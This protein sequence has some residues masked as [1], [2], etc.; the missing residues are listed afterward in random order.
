MEE[1]G[2]YYY[3]DHSNGMDNLVLSNKNEAPNCPGKSEI[4][5]INEQNSDKTKWVSA[6][7]DW[8]YDYNLQT[9]KVTLWDHHFQIPTQKH[10]HVE[11]SIFDAGGNQNMEVYDFP[12]GYT[13][14]YDEV[15]KSGNNTQDLQNIP[16]D[17]QRTVK[18]LVQALD[19]EFSPSF[20]ISDCCTVTPGHKF[21]LIQH[22]VADLNR[23]YLIISVEQELVQ[24]PGYPAMVDEHKQVSNSFRCIPF[25][26]KAPIYKPKRKTASPI[27]QG[28]QTA[29]VVGPKNQEIHTDKY[30]RVKIKFHWD[31]KDD[32]QDNTAWVRVG[33]DIA[34]NKW[35]TMYIPRVGQ[36]VIV[37]FLYGNPDEPIIV[38]SVYNHD[39]MPHYELPK[40]KTLT[41]IKTRTSPDDGKGYN[42]LRFEDKANKEQ[43]FIRSQ[44]R[45]DLRVRGSM[46]ETCGGNRQEVIGFKQENQPGG[47]LAV[48]V[49]GNYDLHVKTDQYITI[50][51][52]LNE[53]VKGD[54][55]EGYDSSQSTV[56]KSKVEINAQTIT[57]E[58]SQAVNLRV[59]SSCIIVDMMGITIQGPM[60]KINSGGSA[61]PTSPVNISDALDAETSDTGEPGYLDKPRTGGGGGRKTRTLNGQHAPSVTKNADGTYS[62]GGDKLRVKGDDKYVSSVMSDLSKMYNTPSGKKGIDDLNAGTGTTTIHAYTPK[63]GAAKNAFAG[64]GAGPS[65]VAD[66][67]NATPAGQP[68]FFGNGAP[69]KDAAGN[70]LMG[71]G[72]GGD[73]NI[74]YNPTDWPDPTTKSKAPGD[75]ILFHEMQHSKNQTTGN[76]DGTPRTD[77]F[78]TNEEFNAIGPENKY[79]DERGV[80]R[81]KNHGD[82]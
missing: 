55:V 25:G 16:A 31:Q 79:R 74:S 26:E 4:P 47:N 39:T 19:A 75:V 56:V 63:P 9:G 59:G 51:G 15:D 35:G 82:L 36:E 41:Y 57:L 28:T 20:A 24:N 61:S 1:E 3:F 32:N 7:S 44:K 66:F 52:K 46:Y 40:F 50:D 18:T 17:K 14:K 67:Q 78:D 8:Q 81:R 22:P 53:G 6:V 45:Y 11:L 30:G 64:P 2:I 10:D 80:P 70:Q 62:V 27:V 42:E 68:V 60:V 34:G 71:T 77:G 5:I 21:K 13:R 23:Q 73:S 48:T 49:A 43:V 12:G 58:G 38:G 69:A 76:Y 72:K 37:D 29:T 33:R 65:T 54:V